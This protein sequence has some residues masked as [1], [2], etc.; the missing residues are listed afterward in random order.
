MP[1]FWWWL[2]NQLFNWI[3]LRLKAAPAWS[4]CN[5]L[6]CNRIMR[7]GG[8]AFRN[9]GKRVSTH[10]GTRKQAE[11]GLVPP[12]IFIIFTLAAFNDPSRAKPHSASIETKMSNASGTGV[13]ISHPC[14]T[15]NLEI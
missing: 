11:R 13:A 12:L 14:S 10:L 3:D 15:L 9:H 4:Q 1:R 2:F 6:F 5:L 8:R 7:R